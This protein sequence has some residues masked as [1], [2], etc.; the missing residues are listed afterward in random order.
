MVTE[1]GMIQRWDPRGA[2]ASLEGTKGVPGMSQVRAAVGSASSWNW[3]LSVPVRV[4]SWG[5]ESLR[6]RIYLGR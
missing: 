2:G 1:Q 4:W 5:K 3:T 6:W